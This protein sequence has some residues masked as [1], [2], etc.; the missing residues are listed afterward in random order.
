MKTLE[1]KS[2]TI[3]G[4][5]ETTYKDLIKACVNN[6]GQ[7]GATMEEQRKRMRILDALESSDTSLELED[8][9]ANLLKG[10]VQSMQWA[11][12]NKNLVEFGDA[13]EKM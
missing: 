11:I 5:K 8:A 3:E 10:L 1:L 13:V 6:V 12:V 9:D 7:Q 4:A 2:F